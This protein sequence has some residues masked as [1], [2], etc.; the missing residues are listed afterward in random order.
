MRNSTLSLV[1]GVLLAAAVAFLALTRMQG[2]WLGL[3]SHM[4]Q[5]N[6]SAGLPQLAT[7]PM[8]VFAFPTPRPPARVGDEVTAGAVA[9]R[10]TGVSHRTRLSGAT[11][12]ESLGRGEEYLVVNVAVRCHSPNDSCRLTGFDFDVR[13]AAGQ[14]A[15]PVFAGRVSGLQLF[16][17]GTI[18]RGRSTSGSLIFIIRQKD[19]GL[20][21]SYPR[22]FGLG[23]S[24]QVALGP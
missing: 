8:S 24:A 22:D 6:Q 17:G 19:R 12:Y 16:D 5:A 10:V 15:R 13:S 1:L 20:V 11:T 14:E 18:A 4:L 9:I 21:L 23:R 3:I 7:T 2:A